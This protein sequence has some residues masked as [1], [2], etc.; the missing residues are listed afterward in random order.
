MELE[1]I[2]SLIDQAVKSYNNGTHLS[3]ATIGALLWTLNKEKSYKKMG[4]K[5]FNEVIRDVKIPRSTVYEMMDYC[6]YIYTATTRFPNLA[7]IPVKSICKTIPAIKATDTQGSCKIIDT[8]VEIAALPDTKEMEDEIKRL[9]GKK[10]EVDCLH[11][12]TE[13][14]N[15]CKVCNKFFKVDGGGL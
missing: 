13:R 5:N 2:K 8:L 15:K 4:Y 11:D 12:E 6:N 7:N 14:Y 3:Y 10:T 9:Y 1:K